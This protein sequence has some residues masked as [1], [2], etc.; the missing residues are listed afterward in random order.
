MKIRNSCN[1]ITDDGIYC[2]CKVVQIWIN[3][4]TKDIVFA[5]KKHKLTD[6]DRKGEPYIRVINLK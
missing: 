6:C 2:G 4:L 1:F 5:C 3:F